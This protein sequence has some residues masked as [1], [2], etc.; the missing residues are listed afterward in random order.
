MD[1]WQAVPR[2]LHWHRL[3]RH[4]RAP[5]NEYFQP[6]ITVR[7]GGR[8]RRRRRPGFFHA[9]AMRSAVYFKLIDDAAFFAAVA[10]D[11]FV[12]TAQLTVNFAK[13]VAKPRLTVSASHRRGGTPF[14]GQ[15]SI[16]DERVGCRGQ[17][18][19]RV[20]AQQDP[21]AGPRMH[22]DLDLSRRQDGHPFST[23]PDNRCAQLAIVVAGS[24]A[25][26]RRRFRESI[27]LMFRSRRSTSTRCA[28]SRAA[29]AAGSSQ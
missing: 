4:M 25:F 22:R 21:L 11:V 23:P 5:I 15:A 6:T 9:A 8:R 20:R 18:A 29:A 26:S 2:R 19:R 12:L 24:A 16:A 13:P 14:Q 17:R 10:P 7:D 3:E 28:F 1:P 27:E